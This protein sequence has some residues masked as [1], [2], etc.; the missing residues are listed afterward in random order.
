MTIETKLFYQVKNLILWNKPSNYDKTAYVL[1][2]LQVKLSTYA[3]KHKKYF[4]N[5]LNNIEYLKNKLALY[6]L[7]NTYL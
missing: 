1:N 7:I 5:Y 4:K 3:V 6:D 2:I